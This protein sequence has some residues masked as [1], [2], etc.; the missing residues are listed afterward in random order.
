MPHVH[1]SPCLARSAAVYTVSDFPDDPQHVRT[2]YLHPNSG[3]IL[4]DIG[5]RDYGTV[6]RA[7]SYGTALHMGRDLSLVNPLL[8][9]AL[10]IGLAARIVTGAIMGCKARPAA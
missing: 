3:A 2:V 7:T 5:Y 9:T 4:R 8:C 1:E 10:S 6:S